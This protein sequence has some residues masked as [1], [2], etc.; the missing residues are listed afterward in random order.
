MTW[1]PPDLTEAAVADAAL[2]RGLGVYGLAPYWVE[3]A[4]PEGLVFGY[5]SLTE[6][7][8]RDGIDLLADAIAALRR[9]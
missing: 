4:G 8:V 9:R 6:S 2:Q 7:A 1:L 3:K 5:G